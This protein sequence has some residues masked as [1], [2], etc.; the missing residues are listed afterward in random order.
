M[1]HTG[2]RLQQLRP[3]GLHHRD[4]PAVRVWP[5][6]SQRYQRD[7]ASQRGQSRAELAPGLSAGGAAIITVIKC[8]LVTFLYT[9]WQ[10]F[11]AGAGAA[12]RDQRAVA[13]AGRRHLHGLLLGRPLALRPRRAGAARPNN[14]NR[15]AANES[16]FKGTPRRMRIRTQPQQAKHRMLSTTEEED[17]DEPGLNNGQS[18]RCGSKE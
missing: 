17:V 15:A 5:A 6:S 11:Q 13:G 10:Y 3:L 1:Q 8:Y 18:A 16:A 7:L 14:P 4:G 2:Q 12:R 9:K